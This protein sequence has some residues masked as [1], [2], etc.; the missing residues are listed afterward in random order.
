MSTPSEPERLS[1]LDALDPRLAAQFRFLIE[2][3]RL[4]S[5]IRACRISDGS[6]KENTAEHS[7]HITLFATVL[8]EH[9]SEPVD[10]SAVVRMLIVHD[11]VEIEAGDVPLFSDAPPGE[12]AEREAQAAEKIFGLLPD[13]QA[14]ELR[15]AWEEFEAAETANARFAKSIDR[16]QPILQNHLVGGGTWT[17]Y[18]VDEATVRAKTG[19]IVDGSPTLWHTA[20]TILADA[21]RSGWLKG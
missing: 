12:Q 20:E 5:V 14:R 21:V 16:L 17:D 18:D 2:A 15:G 3:D 1:W 7:W 13:D 9:S 10:V 6:R 4:K 19:Y 8:A 11:L